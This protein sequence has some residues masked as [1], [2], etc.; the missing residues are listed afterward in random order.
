MDFIQKLIKQEWLKSSSIIQAFQK[1]K[2]Q[3]FLPEDMKG[4]ADLDRALPIGFGQTI[5]QPLVVA[6]ML[7]QLDP[8][9]GHK[10]L[11]IGSGSGWTSALLAEIVGSKGKVIA[12]EIVPALKEFGEHNAGKYN[13][14][15][16]GILEFVCVDGSKGYSQEAPF[17]RILASASGREL[18]LAWKEQ[19]KIKGKIVAPIE[20]SIWTFIKK[21]KNSFEQIEHPGFAFVPLITKD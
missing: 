14:I 18:P 2:R 20:T 10:I 19:L 21:S 17:D 11:D 8:Q 9:P 15:E 3:D 13:F 4:L 6:F 5:S 7:E 1:I 12:V 16:K